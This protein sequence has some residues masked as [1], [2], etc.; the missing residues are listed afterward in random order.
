MKYVFYD[1]ETTGLS[2]AFDSIVQAAAISTDENF[3]IIDQFDLRGQMKKEYPVPHPKA[4]IVNGCTIEQLRNHENTNFGLISEI[5]QTLLSWG[6]LTFIGYNSIAFDEHFL[7]QALYQ[8]ALPPYLTNTNGNKRGDAMKLLHSAAAVFPNAFVRPLNDDT[9]KITFQLEK[10]ASSNGILHSKAHDALSDVE[11]TLGVCKLI[12]ERCGSVWDS[13]LRTVSKQDVF[14]YINQEKV[15][16]VSRFFRGK[17][18]THGL[19]YITKNPSY[20]NQIYCFDL[21]FDPDMVCALDRNELKKMFKGKNKCFH[22]VKANEQPILL[23]EEF[24]YQTE[25]YKDEKPEEIQER[26]K[27]V[28]GNKNFIERFENLILDMSEE[29]SYSDDQSEKPVE[30]QIYNGF[31]DNKDNYL[32]KD[33]HVAAWDK[34]YDIAEKISDMR[35]KEFAKRVIYNEKPEILPKNELSRRDRE[36]AERVLSMDKCKW[37]TIAEAQKEID[38]LREKEDQYDLDRLQEI[39]EYIQELED[40]HKNKLNG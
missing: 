27:K 12:K 8:S 25:E 13:S 38:D 22:L 11:A 5:Q 19:A 34:K 21:K 39:D 36:V 2:S 1:F 32:M 4:L 18:Y 33:F 9:G 3:N 24:L 28:R 14:E 6:E 16:C 31:P 7:R 23:D 15:F 17:E 30:E 40:Y 37:N 26:M 20:E 10:F 29:K 35:I